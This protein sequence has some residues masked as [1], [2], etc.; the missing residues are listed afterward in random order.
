MSSINPNKADSFKY[1]TPSEKENE[2][3]ILPDDV[4]KEIF[5]ILS[6]NEKGSLAAVSKDWNKNIVNLVKNKEFAH[7]INTVKFIIKNLDETSYKTQIEELNKIIS[8]KKILNSVSIKDLRTSISEL[9]DKLSHAL[10]ELKEDDLKKLDNL[11]HQNYPEKNRS[12]D[13]ISVALLLAPFYKQIDEAK[14]LNPI[15]RDEKLKTISTELITQKFFDKSL[16]IALP[17]F[18]TDSNFFEKYISKIVAYENLNKTAISQSNFNRIYEMT[19]QIISK[20]TFP[21]SDNTSPH[22]WFYKHLLADGNDKKSVELAKKLFFNPPRLILPIPDSDAISEFHRVFIT[23]RYNNNKPSETEDFYVFLIDNDAISISSRYITQNF[24]L[25]SRKTFEKTLDAILMR[26]VQRQSIPQLLEFTSKLAWFNHTHSSLLK[27][28]DE[29][30]NKGYNG[31]AATVKK[32]VK[33]KES[34]LGMI[35]D[36]MHI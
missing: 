36:I 22:R 25:G 27:I 24:N 32:Q 10:K 15:E 1:E 20:G 33:R 35:A 8:D 34:W 23:Q 21:T 26:L 19:D 9:Q 17:Y 28:A 2:I 30:E 31:Q 14:N 5:S 3:G 6:D 7:I 11:Y 16:D 18:L 13:S 4:F 29:L 12:N